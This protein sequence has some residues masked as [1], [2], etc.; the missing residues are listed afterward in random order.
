MKVILLKDVAKVGQ[1]YDVKD[2]AS[3]YATNYLIPNN[4]AEIATKTKI[5][6]AEE[7]RKEHEAERKIQG[8]LLAKNIEALED[9]SITIAAKAYEKGS[10]FKGIHE[11]E[12]VTALKEQAHVDVLSHMLVLPEPLKEIGEFDIKV[13]GDG[14][15]GTFK[16]KVEKEA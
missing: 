1:K 6:R 8:E 16:L 9:A 13:E 10:L 11:E 4:L 14:R 3:G 15:S 2:I 12:I 7:L 5:K